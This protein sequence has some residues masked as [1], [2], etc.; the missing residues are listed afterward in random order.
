MKQLLSLT[1][2]LA[3]AHHLTCPLCWTTTSPLYSFV[4]PFLSPRTTT[5]KNKIWLSHFTPLH[6]WSGMACQ[7][8]SGHH[9]PFRLSRKCSK[10]IISAALSPRSRA[11]SAP[12]IR[13]A[14]AHPD[15]AVTTLAGVSN[16]YYY[17]YYYYHWYYYYYFYYY[18]ITYRNCLNTNIWP[19]EIE[20]GRNCIGLRTIIRPSHFRKNKI[21]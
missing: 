7:L 12:Q 15:P 13:F 20:I 17:Y 6:P 16:R 9:L 11:S 14:W 10:R 8:M 2:I 5:L 21:G 4:C 1:K 3:Q 19:T 18:L